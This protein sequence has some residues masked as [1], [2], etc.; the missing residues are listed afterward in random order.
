MENES[1]K[2][3]KEWIKETNRHIKQGIG[4]WANIMLLADADEWAYYL[5]YDERDIQSVAIIFNHVLCN[6]GIKN[7]HVTSENAETFGTI[8]RDLILDMTGY[9]TASIADKEP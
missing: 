1:K 5:D 8:M 9:D 6:V 4:D 7:G 3:S 2:P